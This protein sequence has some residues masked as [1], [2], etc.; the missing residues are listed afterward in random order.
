MLNRLI[1]MQLCGGASTHF[2]WGIKVLVLG[3]PL[4]SPQFVERELVKVASQEAFLDRVP[5][6]SELQSAWLLLLF[7]ASLRP[8]YI[9]WML[10]CALVHLASSQFGMISA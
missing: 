2:S 10:H 6:V 3:T 5:H 7:C 9:F 8:N 1:L 4:G